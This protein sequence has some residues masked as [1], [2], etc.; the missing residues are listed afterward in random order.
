MLEIVAFN[1]ESRGLRLIG[2]LDLST[3][4]TLIEAVEEPLA[5]GEGD[6]LLDLSDLVF[7]DSSGLRAMISIAS[8]LRGNGKL[9]FL[10]PQPMILRLFELSGVLHLSNLELRQAHPDSP[11]PQPPPEGVR[12]LLQ[13]STGGA[14]A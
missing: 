10:S 13:P 7:M 5:F 9:V 3:T 1:S 12:S 6:L 8:Q 11:L 2:E 4:Q 14:Q